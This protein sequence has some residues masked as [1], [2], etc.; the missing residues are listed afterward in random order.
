MAKQRMSFKLE[1]GECEALKVLAKERRL[2]VSSTGRELI[3]QGLGMTDTQIESVVHQLEIVE[4]RS[5]RAQIAAYRAYAGMVELIRFIAKEGDAAE[6]I[7]EALVRKS[8]ETLRKES[9]RGDYQ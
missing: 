2:T 4:K 6:E 7:L 9:E 3:R 5:R 8:R 1:P